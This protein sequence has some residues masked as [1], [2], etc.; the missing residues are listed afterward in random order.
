MTDTLSKKMKDG[1]Q[2][3]NAQM[4]DSFDQQTVL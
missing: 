4:G 2:R 1:T 3:S